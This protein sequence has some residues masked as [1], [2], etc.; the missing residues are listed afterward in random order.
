MPYATP[1]TINAKAI[2]LALVAEIAGDNGVSGFTAPAA[3]LDALEA[4]VVAYDAD[5][6]TGERLGV[7]YRNR[8]AFWTEDC[9]VQ[10]ASGNNGEEGDAT[11]LLELCDAGAALDDAL[12]AIFEAL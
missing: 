3:L 1:S 8:D 11:E 12:N 9:I 7:Y 4:A 10:L 6:A 5:L 2:A